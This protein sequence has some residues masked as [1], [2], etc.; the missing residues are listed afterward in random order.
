MNTRRDIVA[1][2]NIT[3][4]KLNAA[5]Q[6]RRDKTPAERL[7]WESIRNRRLAGFKFRRQQIVAGFVVDLYCAEAGV[8]V[9][10]D[11]SVHTDQVVA[12]EQRDAILIGLG[13]RVVRFWNSQV[14]HDLPGVLVTLETVLRDL[15]PRPPLRNG[16]GV[17]AH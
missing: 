7:L 9:E 1:G 17:T 5:R 8:V 3:G 11:G 2:Q 16:E 14:E 15:T 10:L 4:E 12:D 6:L 13:L